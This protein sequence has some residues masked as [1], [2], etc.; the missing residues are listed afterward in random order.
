LLEIGHN[1]LPAGS[2]RFQL[3]DANASSVAAAGD[4]FDV[5]G[6]HLYR[7]DLGG[8]VDNPDRGDSY[9]PTTSA[10]VYMP[11]RGAQA[12]KTGA[13]CWKARRRRIW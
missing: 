5:Y 9:V 6:A 10:A 1:Q 11:R 8:M 7:S 3:V 2:F 12:G 4:S 13:C